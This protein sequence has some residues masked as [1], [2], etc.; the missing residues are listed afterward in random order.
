[1]TIPQHGKIGICIAGWHLTKLPLEMLLGIRASQLYIIS[2]RPLAEV[3]TH[4]ASHPNIELLIRPNIGYDWGCYQQFIESGLWQNY[5]YLFF[6]HDDIQIHNIGFVERACQLLDQ[7]A[8]IV[9][10][11]RNSSELIRAY[12]RLHYYAHASWLPPYPGFEHDTVRGSFFA[13]K[14]EV[15]EKLTSFEVFWDPLHLSLGY[16][17]YSLV[18]SSAKI[19]AFFEDY[20]FD[21]LSETYLESEFISEEVRGGGLVQRGWGQLHK[22]I[23]VRLYSFL[24]KREVAYRL[25]QRNRLI[26]GKGISRLITFLNGRDPERPVAK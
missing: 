4:L 24:A 1:M 21:F 23:L 7:G 15:L 12:D 20:P 22:T 18:A 5:E 2:H 26:F 25:L 17:N 9:G 16:G 13:T 3:P 10:N 6:M 11:G 8:A 19:H 14:R